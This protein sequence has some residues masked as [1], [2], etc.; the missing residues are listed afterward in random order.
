IQTLAD[1]TT[2]IDN[3]TLNGNTIQ[4]FAAMFLSTPDDAFNMLNVWDVDY[5]VLFV[6]G[7]KLS[8]KSNLE[9]SLYVLNGGGDES[10]KQ[11]FMRIAKIQ[12]VD[13]NTIEFPFEKYSNPD[14][15]TGTDYFWNETLLGNAIPLSN[16]L[17]HINLDL[18]LFLLRKLNMIMIVILH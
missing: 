12:Q 15:L 4:K 2:L 6:A 14:G 10:K 11:W 7:E 13:G 3:A 16:N 8:V 1:R 17:H 18:F 5:L 9:D